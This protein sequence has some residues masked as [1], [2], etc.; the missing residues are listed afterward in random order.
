MDVLGRQKLNR[1]CRWTEDECDWNRRDQIARDGEGVM[2]KMNGI[3]GRHLG[4]N[5]ET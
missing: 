5:V 3:L 4:D 1:F 2:G